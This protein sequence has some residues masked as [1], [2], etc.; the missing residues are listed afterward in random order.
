MM[1]CASRTA[2]DPAL[3]YQQLL[4]GQLVATTPI[5]SGAME[6]GVTIGELEP[7]Y[8]DFDTPSVPEREMVKIRATVSYLEDQLQWF[9][10]RLEGHAD[11]RGS[12]DYNFT[13]GLERAANVA[14]LLAS[15]GISPYRLRVTSYGEEFP[16]A[17]GLGESDRALN[18]R[19]EFVI[20]GP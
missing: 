2:I 13:L 18:R 20:V 17:L 16:V 8:F 19:V 12:Y 5:G 4:A 10:I 9:G 3:A 14:A 7:I 11:D 6:E 1:S 15:L